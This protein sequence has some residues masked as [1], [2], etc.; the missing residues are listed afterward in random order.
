MAFRNL[1]LLRG[2]LMTLLPVTRIEQRGAS[3]TLMF[4]VGCACFTIK[5]QMSILPSDLAVKN[6]AGRVGDQRAA[7]VWYLFGD[8]LDDCNGCYWEMKSLPSHFNLVLAADVSGT[9]YGPTCILPKEYDGLPKVI[10][11]RI[12][13]SFIDLTDAKPCQLDW[14]DIT[15]IN[16]FDSI[17]HW[18]LVMSYGYWAYDRANS[19]VENEPRAWNFSLWRS[20]SLW[21]PRTRFC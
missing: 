2:F 17:Y 1:C 9:F 3:L 12:P 20:P 6:T 14:L 13:E 10:V 21:Y 19:R 7:D 5:S 15:L 16:Y 4:K 18:W 11:L 8:S